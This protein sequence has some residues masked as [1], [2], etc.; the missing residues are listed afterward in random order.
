MYKYVR[1]EPQY[2]T[3]C[4]RNISHR[5]TIA[6]YVENRTTLPRGKRPRYPLD[7]RLGG[8]RGWSRRRGENSWPYRD[9]NFDP[10]VVQPP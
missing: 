9:S 2:L 6:E 5:H 3:P 8:P 4:E 7:R 1:H 10:S